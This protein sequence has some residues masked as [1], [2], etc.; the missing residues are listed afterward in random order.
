MSLYCALAVTQVDPISEHFRYPILNDGSEM[1]VE[2]G[3]VHI[4]RSTKQSRVQH[5][6]LALDSCTARNAQ[7]P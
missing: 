6:S 4:R 7:V 3:P 2:A 5:I 1:L